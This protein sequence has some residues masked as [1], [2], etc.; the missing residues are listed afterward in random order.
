[1]REQQKSNSS[2]S[3]GVHK[4]RLLYWVSVLGTIQGRKSKAHTTNRL[5]AQV[6]AGPLTS[7]LACIEI[8][9]TI[10]IINCL[11][12]M[13]VLWFTYSC[14][15]SSPTFFFSVKCMS[16]VRVHQQSKW[17]T[18]KSNKE[19]RSNKIG[20]KVKINPQIHSAYLYIK[21]KKVIKIIKQTTNK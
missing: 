18:K 11:S 6:R 4:E 13:F 2:E 1:M 15:L 12:L 7:F 9:L 3:R 8:N 14:S 21:D 10:Q 5:W 19:I 20:T 17:L 16:C